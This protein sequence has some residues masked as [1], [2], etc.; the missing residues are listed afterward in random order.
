[1]VHG[2]RIPVTYGCISHSK[3]IH[4]ILYIRRTRRDSVRSS[5]VASTRIAT[6][7]LCL[8]GLASLSRRYGHSKTP[9]Q[10]LVSFP[11][12]IL[13]DVNALNSTNV[14]ASFQQT[15]ADNLVGA[16]TSAYFTYGLSTIFKSSLDGGR[17]R[18][19][20]F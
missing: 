14:G 2:E 5:R 1:M 15:E 9:L 13:G 10:N 3:Q 19:F 12:S 16:A 18:L 4:D 6:G 11:K 17:K 20:L 7:F 8:V